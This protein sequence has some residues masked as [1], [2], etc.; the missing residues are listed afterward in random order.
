LDLQQ[1]FLTSF[2]QIEV[3][4]SV[5]DGY[6]VLDHPIASPLPLWVFDTLPEHKKSIDFCRDSDVALVIAKP[7]VLEAIKQLTPKG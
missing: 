6:L 2:D 7:L 5:H 3:K 1:K 4:C